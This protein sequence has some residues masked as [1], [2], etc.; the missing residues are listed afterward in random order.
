MEMKSLGPY[1]SAYQPSKK[2]AKSHKK[3]FLKVIP[4]QRPIEKSSNHQYPY[5]KTKLYLD[6]QWI[7]LK[8]VAS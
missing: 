8:T 3:V 6:Y 5:R 7:V 1:K 4:C 2:N